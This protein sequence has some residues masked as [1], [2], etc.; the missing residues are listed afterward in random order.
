MGDAPGPKAKLPRG[1]TETRFLGAR[2]PSEIEFI[3]RI[4]ESE[5]RVADFVYSRLVVPFV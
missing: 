5:L 3:G 2:R 4:L 1:V